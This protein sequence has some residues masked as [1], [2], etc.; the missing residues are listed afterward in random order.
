MMI[1]VLVMVVVVVVVVAV[2]V[3]SMVEDEKTDDENNHAD[4]VREPVN[5]KAQATCKNGEPV[6]GMIYLAKKQ[7]ER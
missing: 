1:A 3:R 2:V 4:R 6:K 7:K 5:P